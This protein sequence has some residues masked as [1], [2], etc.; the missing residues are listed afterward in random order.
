MESGAT[1]QRATQHAVLQAAIGELADAGIAHP[2]RNA[3]W[4]L[5][6]VLDCN[7][8]TLYAYPERH[9]AVEDRARLEQMVVRRTRHEPLQYIVGHE[10]FYGLRLQVT[11]DVLIPRPETEEVV[12]RALRC[13]ASHT[14]PRVLDVGTGSGC[15]AL[16]IQHERPDAIVQAC[17]VSSEALAVARRNA[18]M[19]D[20]AVNFVQAD[21]LSDAFIE[22]VAVP[23]HLVV[24]NPPYIPDSEAP[25]L[26]ADVQDYEPARAL[27]TGADP[28]RFYRAIVRH[29]PA[30]LD[31]DG[32]LT[33][34]THA[35]YAGAVRALFDAPAWHSMDVHQDMSGRP[36][37]VL[38]QKAQLET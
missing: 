29:A 1:P 17:D 19:H 33:L 38:A 2:R 20:L 7:R 36:R 22:Q 10:D 30:L 3:E 24:S 8:A 26:P 23:F 21:V 16:A 11:P 5:A 12:E 34:E 4:L 32:W 35:E 13:I 37:V 28:L 18:Q 6:A 25:R 31:T 14:A 27:F 9:V 15:I